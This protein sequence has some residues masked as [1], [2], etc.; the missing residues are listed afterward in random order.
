VVFRG[1]LRSGHG[2]KASGGRRQGYKGG[3]IMKLGHFNPSRGQRDGQ[4]V[5]CGK[6]SGVL[7]LRGKN[8]P[9]SKRETGTPNRPRRFQQMGESVGSK[10]IRRTTARQKKGPCVGGPPQNSRVRVNFRIERGPRREESRA[11]W[12]VSSVGR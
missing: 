3:T 4:M 9:D 1:S 11:S 12:G 10:T 2:P 7:G 6:E 8:H 5:E